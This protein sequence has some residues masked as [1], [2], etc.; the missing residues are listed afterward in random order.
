MKS[1]SRINTND[2]N[3]WEVIYKD[4]RDN[5]LNDRPLAV[6]GAA[7]VDAYLIRA[8]EWAMVGDVDQ[9]VI[10]R[11]FDYGGGALGSMS[12]RI[13]I[14]AAMGVIDSTTHVHLNSIRAIRNEFAHG[15]YFRDKGSNDTRAVSFD[16]K[17]IHLLCR[18]FHRAVGGPKDIDMR[19]VFFRTIFDTL[20]AL[21][22]VAKKSRPSKP[23]NSE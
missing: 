7:M 13:E 17:E 15:L 18:R 20:W 11:L 1:K 19:D 16:E 6:I 22:S 8:L 3:E 10:D 4:F 12:A 23:L 21:F 5:R 9:K 2:P 14:A